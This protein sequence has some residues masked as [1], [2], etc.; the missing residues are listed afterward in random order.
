[1]TS[2]FDERSGGSILFDVTDRIGFVTFNRPARL[3]AINL[4]MARAF[5]ELVYR[6]PSRDDV[7]VVV[8][9]GAGA[10]FMA[11]GDIELF[12]GDPAG[13]TAT[14]S[15]LID[16]F[17][18]LTVGLQKLPQPVIGS[19]HGAVAGGGFSLALGTDMTIAA[20]TATFTPAY[21]RLG[22]TPDGGGTFFLSRLVGAKR[23]MEIF[24]TGASYTALE[25]QRLGLINRVVPAAELEAETRKL[26]ELLAGRASPAVGG[27][28]A[29]LK[30]G[31]LEALEEQLA[32]EKASFLGCISS[33]DFKEGV[34][35]FLEKRAP[36]FGT[37]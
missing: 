20:D 30:R 25:A 12:R 29:L 1:M 35:S 2:S 19:V 4:E 13:V 18:A 36:R 37:T 22:T 17:H 21:L 33:A 5:R 26:A 8:L 11:G 34:L 9:R 32:A 23:A 6:L 27:T 24:L 31:D 14:V 10:A 16:N 7:R 15:E 28:K 3:N